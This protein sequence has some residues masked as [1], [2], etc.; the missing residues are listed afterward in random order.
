MF[1]VH[2]IIFNH[3]FVSLIMFNMCRDASRVWHKMQVVK[4]LVKCYQLKKEG[5][6]VIDLEADS[7]QDELKWR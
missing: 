3:Y 4:R 5:I 2:M 1:V 7:S 6:L